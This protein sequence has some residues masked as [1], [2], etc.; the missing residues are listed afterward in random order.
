MSLLYH[1]YSLTSIGYN[2]RMHESLLYKKLDFPLVECQL[3]HHYCR[4]SDNQVGICG[5]RRNGQGRLYSLNYGRVIAE[6][7]DPIEKKP[8]FHFLP[9]SS[10]YS[11]ASVG[12]NLRCGNCQNWQISQYGKT[13]ETKNKKQIL[14]PGYEV[15]AQEIVQR[16]LESSCQ[17]IA[18]TYTEP[19]IFFEFALA[20][21]REAKL[22]NLKNVW[23]SNGYMTNEC[24]T[25]ILPYLDAMN[26]DLK[27]FSEKVYLENC[28]CRL[29]PV[30]DNLKYLVKQP[31]TLEITTLIVPGLTNLDD[32]PEKIAKF[33]AQELST[34]VPWHISKFS[35]DISYKM[36]DRQDTPENLLDN[37]YQLG[38]KAGLKY[39][40]LGN[41]SQHQ[42]ESTYC[43]QCGAMVI[44]RNGYQI[45]RR[46]SN[47]SCPNC[48]Y[49]LPLKID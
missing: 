3:C 48:H 9:G 47:G 11:I 12:C 36:H 32:Q 49:H 10:A 44:W 45:E 16:A 21:M 24:L 39:V 2:S 30:L 46:D 31:L 29:Q 33:I 41:I 8:L 42:S 20:C 22:R 35:S 28:G 18:Y 40:Y 37:I 38:R 26:V 17:S 4:L 43:P 23:V 19:T 5:V 15:T 34:D 1:F 14:I 6:A 7:V 13:P 27:F 25:E